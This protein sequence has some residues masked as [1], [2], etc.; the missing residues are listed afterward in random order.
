MKIK[1]NKDQL[2]K[3]KPLAAIKTLGGSV[4]GV[5]GATH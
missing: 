5:K 1:K 2:R 3:G 4:T